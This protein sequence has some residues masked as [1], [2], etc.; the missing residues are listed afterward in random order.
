MQGLQ[1]V[2][3]VARLQG[4]QDSYYLF[5]EASERFFRISNIYINLMSGFTYVYKMPILILMFDFFGYYKIKRH[6]IILC[7]CRKILKVRKK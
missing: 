5:L 1:L 2:T 4:T 6:F 7:R 3:T